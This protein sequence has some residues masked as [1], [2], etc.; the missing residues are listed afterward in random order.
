V[1]STG[2]GTAGHEVTFHQTVS[3]PT[4]DADGNQI[5]HTYLEY[6]GSTAGAEGSVNMWLIIDTAAGRCFYKA[7]GSLTAS[8]LDEEGIYS[9]TFSA[10]YYLE[11]GPPTFADGSPML[12][13]GTVDITVRYW[14]DKTSLFAASVAL[15][16]S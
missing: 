1:T 8:T 2:R 5:G 15:Q 14:S 9:Y 13:D 3:G 10:G 11:S 7:T 6:W 12:H 16:E 4:L